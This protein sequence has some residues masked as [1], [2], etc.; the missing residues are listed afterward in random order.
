LLPLYNGD[1][2]IGK[3]AQINAFKHIVQTAII[4]TEMQKISVEVKTNF[5]RRVLLIRNRW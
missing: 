2:Q 4:E 1:S 5:I 3:E